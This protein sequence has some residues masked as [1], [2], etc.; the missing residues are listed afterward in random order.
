[1]GA[2]AIALGRRFSQGSSLAL[3]DDWTGLIRHADLR[4]DHRRNYVVPG[5]TRRE[6]GTE[7][8]ATVSGRR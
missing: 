7:T 3:L 8:N 2:V 5:A 6:W 1:M 4:R